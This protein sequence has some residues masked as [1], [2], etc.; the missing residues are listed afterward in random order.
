[1]PGQPVIRWS[2]IKGRLKHWAIRSRNVH[3]TARV[4]FAKAGWSTNGEYFLD[5]HTCIQFAANDVGLPTD[6]SKAGHNEDINIFGKRCI[7]EVAPCF[8]S[9]RHEKMFSPVFSNFRCHQ[10]V[11]LRKP[12][13]TARNQQRV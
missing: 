1:M 12:A 2:L 6:T 10:T 9:G 4:V 3:G 11:G 13:K 7:F 8:S 5:L